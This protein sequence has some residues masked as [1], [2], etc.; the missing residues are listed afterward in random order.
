MAQLASAIRPLWPGG[1]FSLLPFG[2]EA[3]PRSLF[4][5][6]GHHSWRLSLSTRPLVWT[7]ARRRARQRLAFS[8]LV[9]GSQASA[10]TLGCWEFLFFP[11]EPTKR[12]KGGQN[13]KWTKY[14][15]MNIGIFYEEKIEKWYP[16]VSSRCVESFYIKRSF[17]FGSL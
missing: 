13:T 15:T 5:Q 17:F 11:Y 12:S 6:A 9:A 2:P 8:L 10:T 1:G 7:L 14:P 4:N 3:L 16:F